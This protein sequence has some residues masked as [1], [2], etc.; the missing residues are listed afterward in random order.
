MLPSQQQRL[1]QSMHLRSALSLQHSL[2]RRESESACHTPDDTARL[3][4][5]TSC[6]ASAA[7]KASGSLTGLL[8]LPSL[9]LSPFLCLIPLLLSPFLCVRL[10]AVVSR[11]VSQ[12]TRPFASC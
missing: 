9:F 10:P 2:M 3:W 4:S 6:Q 5:R 7:G 1:R 12:G 11:I 8:S